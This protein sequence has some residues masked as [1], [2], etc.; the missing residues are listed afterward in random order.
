MPA[1]SAPSTRSLAV[2]QLPG[3]GTITSSPGC[4]SAGVKTYY[5]EQMCKIRHCATA[6]HISTCAECA[7][8][9]CA[10]LEE[11]FNSVPQAKA[12]LDELRAK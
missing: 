3:G 2:P 11:I 1:L 6:R 7:D 9:P 8:Y 12:T 4:Q 10:S 5:C